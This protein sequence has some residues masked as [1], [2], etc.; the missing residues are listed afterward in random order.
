MTWIII[1]LGSVSLGWLA[2]A[3]GRAEG[4]KAN[5]IGVNIASDRR[6]VATIKISD[7]K[8]KPLD[9]ADLDAGSIKLTIAKIQIGK[10]GESEYHNYILTRI[11]GK[12]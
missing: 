6:P 11:V 1:F 10:N 4:L 5:I 2:P 7:A 3:I 8:G 9:L 12:D